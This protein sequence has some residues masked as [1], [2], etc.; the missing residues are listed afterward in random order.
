MRLLTAALLTVSLSC[1]S[2]VAGVVVSGTSERVV[3]K[4]DD[5]TMGDIAAALRSTCNLDVKLIGTTSRTVSGVYTGSLRRVLSHVLTGE[6]YVISVTSGGMR[7]VLKPGLAAAPLVVEAS[8]PEAEMAPAPLQAPS[9]MIGLRQARL[10]A[11]GVAAP[12]E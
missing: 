2:A 12:N 7:I 8:G 4:A 11:R 6:N 5:A 1:G 3:L 10:K 9:R